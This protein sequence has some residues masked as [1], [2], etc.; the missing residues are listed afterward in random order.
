M[1]APT[2]AF[3]AFMDSSD[4]QADTESG[5]P[6][7]SRIEEADEVDVR[8]DTVAGWALLLA[9]VGLIGLPFLGIGVI[10]SVAAV[11]TIGVSRRR[12]ADGGRDTTVGRVAWILGWAGIAVFAV[13]LIVTGI[14]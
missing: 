12:R 11:Q 7:Y 6:G 4:Q 13:G 14:I 3:R 5:Y 10:A 1:A 9:I 2:A 8:G